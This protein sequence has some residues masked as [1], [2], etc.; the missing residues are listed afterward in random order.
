MGKTFLL[1]QALLVAGLDLR[2]KVYSLD[3]K[4]TGDLASTQLFAHF[5]S[6]GA[7][8]DEIERVRAAVRELRAELLKRADIIDSLTREQCPESKVT[9]ELA[10]K[11]RSLCPIVVGIDET[12]SYFEYGDEGT[13]STR[14]SGRNSPRASRSW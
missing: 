3:G 6:R 9:S 5:Y 11:R 4:G 12:Q 7:K 2:A 1:R 10:D 13:R 14:R 8:P